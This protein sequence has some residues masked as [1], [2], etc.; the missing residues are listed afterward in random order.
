MGTFSYR[1]DSCSVLCLFSL[2]SLCIEKQCFF[3]TGNSKSCSCQILIF[4]HLLLLCRCHLH[5]P[6]VTFPHLYLLCTRVCWVPLCFKKTGFWKVCWLPKVV[7]QT[8]L[9]L[10]LL[11]ENWQNRQLVVKK[12]KW[13]M[14]KISL[15]KW[16]KMPVLHEQRVLTIPCSGHPLVFQWRRDLDCIPLMSTDRV[17]GVLFL[18]VCVKVTLAVT[19]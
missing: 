4:P 19:C 1:H 18:G 7:A 10:G 6:S 9:V 5:H 17:C 8:S 16:S 12:G 11:Y 2:F 15:S 14:P 13:T 3:T